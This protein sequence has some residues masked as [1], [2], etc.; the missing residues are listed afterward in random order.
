MG[1]SRPNCPLHCLILPDGFLKGMLGSKSFLLCRLFI[2]T[3]EVFCFFLTYGFLFQLLLGNIGNDSCRIILMKKK[4]LKL[5]SQ[6]V[7]RSFLQ[8]KSVGAKAAA[9]SRALLHA[10][11]ASP[12]T[13]AITFWTQGCPR[14]DTAQCSLF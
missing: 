8:L 1:K 11:W 9:A 7:T 13:L 5:R 12:G 6:S 10:L 14:F 3:L 4:E 2:L